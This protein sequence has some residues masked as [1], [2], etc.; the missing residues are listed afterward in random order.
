MVYHRKTQFGSGGG[1]SGL[2]IG[3]T[4]DQ[5]LAK[6]SN[7]D[8]DASW[9]D[10]HYVPA[11]GTTNQVLTKNS[12]TNYDLIWTTP[13]GSGSL[14]PFTDHAVVIA[15]STSTITSLS[16][17]GTTTTLLHGNDSGD[18][19]WGAVDLANDVTGNLAVTHLNNGTNASISTYWRG[20]ETWA[21]IPG[22]A[23]G[24]VNP[25]L[26]HNSNF[27]YWNSPVHY[28]VIFGTYSEHCYRWYGLYGGEEG[29]FETALSP[30]ELQVIRN[31]STA[32]DTPLLLQI[33]DYDDSIK[34]AGK[35]VTISAEIYVSDPTRLNTF[36][37]LILTG[38]GV[39]ETFDTHNTTGWT[40]ENLD[41]SGNLAS[42]ITGSYQIISYSTTITASALQVAI[43][44]IVNWSS[45]SDSVPDT[46]YI[47]GI[48]FVEGTNAREMDTKSVAVVQHEC[49][50]YKRVADLYLRDSYESH[51]IDMRDIPTITVGVTC[52]TTGTTKDT[53]IIKTNSS[54]DNGVHTV[55]LDCELI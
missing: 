26:A 5:V 9:K 32:T 20:D 48:Y 39:N 17:L 21:T 24:S 34:F 11:G 3:G 25:N 54:S 7:T 4:T 8:Y 51:L 29:A 49:C 43:G 18:P 45:Y 28:S 16:S 1:G 52:T 40:N 14:G 10:A 55:T 30:P 22:G 46:L 27:L 37:F 33:F 35:D 42:S 15:D 13:T 19:S 47:K 12:N 38:E 41:Y 50:R 36:E 53:L 44:F 31:T 2:P 6:N 23:G